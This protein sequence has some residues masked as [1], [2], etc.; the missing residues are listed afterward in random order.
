MKWTTNRIQKEAK[1]Q[2]DTIALATGVVDMHIYAIYTK[3][4][5]SGMYI[6]GHFYTLGKIITFEY[7]LPAEVN[8]RG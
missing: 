5:R 7:P 2:I 1:S 4:T 8:L 6:Y 3:Y